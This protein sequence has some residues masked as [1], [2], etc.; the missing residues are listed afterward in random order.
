MSVFVVCLAEGKAD[1]PVRT[2]RKE[3]PPK[4]GKEM[5]VIR[6]PPPLIQ[7]ETTPFP[8]LLISM[9][10][11]SLD[12]REGDEEAVGCRPE[13]RGNPSEHHLGVGGALGD[14]VGRLAGGVVGAV[15]LPAALAAVLVVLLVSAGWKKRRREG[16]RRIR[17]DLPPTGAKCCT[18]PSP[19][20]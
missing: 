8:T 19:S 14:A 20:C 11:S 4:T 16:K 6:H 5:G 18:P 7:A 9:W 2:E 12:P 15:V 13:R 17:G 1:Y 3:N 10:Y